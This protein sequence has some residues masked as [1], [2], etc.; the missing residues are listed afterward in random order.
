MIGFIKNCTSI[1]EDRSSYFKNQKGSAGTTFFYATTLLM[2]LSLPVTLFLVSNQNQQVSRASQEVVDFSNPPT[3]NVTLQSSVIQKGQGLSVHLEVPNSNWYTVYYTKEYPITSL[4]VADIIEGKGEYT[5][6]IRAVYKGSS[7][8]DFYYMPSE[9]GYVVAASYQLQGVY[10]Q[11]RPGDVM[12]MWDGSLYMYQ[13]KSGN[14][15]KE[16]FD[17]K[18][19]Y[20]GEWKQLTSC[21]NVGAVKVEVR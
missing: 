12:C 16:L 6:A 9:S 4:S 3:V 14:P 10:G 21:Q 11:F 15:L 5:G 20:D 19:K 18:A 17:E 2:L 8:K 1:L 13:K 7:T